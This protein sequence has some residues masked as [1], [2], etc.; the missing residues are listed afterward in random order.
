VAKD[1]SRQCL[2]RLLAGSG[3][4]LLIVLI[5]LSVLVILALVLSRS[6]GLTLWYF[7]LGPLQNRYS[8]G[9][10]INAAIPLIFGG[11]GV[12]VAMQAGS[13]NLGGEGQIYAGACITVTVALA[14][15]PLGFFGAV[16]AL[17]AGA[18]FSGLTAA[19]SGA[20]KERW[21][22]NELISSF[23]LSNALILII[24]YLVTG[25]LL[26]PGTNLQATRKVSEAFRLPRILPP[27][28]LSAA[29][30]FALA[31]VLLVHI[32]LYRSRWGYEIRMTG[33]SSRFARYGGVNLVRSAVFPMFL[34]GALYGIAG[35]MAVYGTYYTV[36]KEFSAG[37]GWNGLAVALIAR[38]RPGAVIPA[39]IFFSWIGSGARLAMQFSDVNSE[40]ASIVQ[41]V[42][43]LLASS[44]SLRE[45]F[46]RSGPASKGGLASKGGQ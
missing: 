37:L 4:L 13:F 18:A 36:M 32:F 40:L 29:L 23:L 1:R 42:V 19:V 16:V 2:V 34:S 22:T 3:G 24:N 45:V 20:L 31:A 46:S 6:P 28:N 10:M 5:A 41:A 43:F 12:A 11:L 33:L 9:N 39:A 25:P 15:E 8:F 30:F 14:L 27:S 38:S 21:N 17:I 44:L 35:G 26:D 7:F